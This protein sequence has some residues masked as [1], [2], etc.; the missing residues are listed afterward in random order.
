MNPIIITLEQD[1][2]KLVISVVW[3]DEIGCFVGQI[4]GMPEK[5]T[6]DT[7]GEIFDKLSVANA[8]VINAAM[9]KVLGGGR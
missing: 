5:R 2:D 6:G 8:D 4:V 1:G 9:N 7:I 3:S